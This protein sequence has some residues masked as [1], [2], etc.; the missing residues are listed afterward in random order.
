[1]GDTKA[2]ATSIAKR[3]QDELNWPGDSDVYYVQTAG[4]PSRKSFSVRAMSGTIYCALYVST[5]PSPL[6][7]R[8]ASPGEE[9]HISYDVYF[10]ATYYFQIW[11][12]VVHWVPAMA[13][14][15]LGVVTTSC[16]TPTYPDEVGNTRGCATWLGERS[17][18]EL[19]WPGD[20][21]WYY[22]V[23]DGALRNRG[24]AVLNTTSG[25]ISCDVFRN[26]STD[27]MLSVT[28]LPGQECYVGYLANGFLPFY[29][30]ISGGPW[31][32]GMQYMPLK[33]VS[34]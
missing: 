33:V 34:W 21:D 20:V 6:A 9:Y 12:D 10:S 15:S 24:F 18:D 30:K 1:V 29:F 25:T 27:P 31:V 26:T 5:S 23:N 17:S 7:T 11:T 28:A 8:T 4:L 19:N 2:C 16:P 14:E 32:P 22:I 3:N 13:H